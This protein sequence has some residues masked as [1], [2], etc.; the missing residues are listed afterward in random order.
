MLTIY[1]NIER[2]P[3][4]YFNVTLT[5]AGPASAA[6]TSTVPRQ[7]SWGHSFGL[8]VAMPEEMALLQSLEP[9]RDG[10]AWGLM[11]YVHDRIAWN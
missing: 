3:F 1:I 7:P 5:Y 6:V 11:Q 8:A 9:G 4:S 2:G 10:E